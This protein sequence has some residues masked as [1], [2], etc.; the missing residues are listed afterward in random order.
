[1]NALR[2]RIRG[3]G[4]PLMLEDAGHFVQEHGDVIAHAALEAWS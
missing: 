2:E 4:E 1:M 3:C